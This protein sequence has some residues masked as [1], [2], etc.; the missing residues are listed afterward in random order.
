VLSP[1]QYILCTDDCRSW[2]DN[3]FIVQFADD[4]AIVS[5]LG[6][7][8]CDHGPVVE[9]CVHCCNDAFLQIN[10][11]KTKD[12]LIDFSRNQ[13][14]LKRTAIKEQ[15]VD[16]V[17][18]YKYL[19]CVIDKKL[20]FN[21]NVEMICK[22]GQQRLYCLQRLSK[23]KVDRSLMILF[24]KSYIESVL[25]FSVLCWY[26]SLGVKSALVKVVN[27]SSEILGVQQSHPAGLDTAGS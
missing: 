15:E 23:F 9:D 18:S 16:V 11:L 20:N 25:T 12:M 4:S 13:T 5:L 27:T 1:L 10:V 6:A 14:D 17:G 8:E 2:H 22:R 19:G 7:G 24:Y 3:R 26:G 21:V